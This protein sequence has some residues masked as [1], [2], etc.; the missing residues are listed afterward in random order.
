MAAPRG[1][2]RRNTAPVLPLLTIPRVLGLT[3]VFA[4]V[5]AG[6]LFRSTTIDYEEA[7]AAWEATLSSSADYRKGWLN[8]WL[9][10]RLADAHVIARFPS[11]RAA[12]EQPPTGDTLTPLPPTEE[13]HLRRALTAALDDHATDSIVAIDPQ[14]RIAFAQGQFTPPTTLLFA[15][16]ARPPPTCDVTV[17]GRLFL[18]FSAPVHDPDAAGNPLVGWV[19]LLADPAARLWPL[20]TRERVPT[21]T[22][23]TI[24]LRRDGDRIVYV[25]PLRFTES[26]EPLDL[27]ADMPNLAGRAATEGR[28][29]FAEWRDYRGERI[30]AATR[31]L[32]IPGWGLVR[33]VDA[34][35]AFAPYAKAVR[36]SVLLAAVGVLA[37]GAVM[38]SLS[39]RQKARTLDAALRQERQ[40]RAVEERYRQLINQANDIMLV[41]QPD[42]RIVEANRRAE[43]TYGYTRD[44]L[45]ELNARALRAPETQAPP[46]ED[47]LVRADSGGIVVEG[48]HRRR[49]GSTFPV[50]A[51]I[52]GVHLSGEHLYLTVIRDITER[53]RAE[54]ALRV[55][56]ARF[57][58]L[59]DHAAVAMGILD[60]D[61]RIVEANDALC[62]LAGLPRD[63]L[64]GTSH[65]AY[66]H[67][68]DLAVT[69]QMFGTV[70]G[71]TSDTYILEKRYVTAGAH[72][73]WARLSAA[74][75]RDG[76]GRPLYVTAIIDDITEQKLAAEAV[77][78]ANAELEERVAQR[79]A[80]L[81]DANAELSAF[82]YS[83][84][85]DLRAP[86]RHIEGFIRI[87]EEDYADRLP[88]EGRRY[89]ERVRAGS[90][91]LNQLIDALLRLVRVGRAELQPRSVN[92]TELAHATFEDL[93]QHRN[94]QAIDFVVGAL[95]RTCGDPVLLR[96]L[97][98]NLIGNAIKFTRAVPGARIE[99]GIESCN[100]DR[101]FYV[102][103]NGVGFDPAYAE[104]LFRVFQ[105]LHSAHDFEGTGIGLS[106]VKRIVERHGGKV[107]AESVPGQG[108]TFY[109]TLPEPETGP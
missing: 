42:G 79:T 46:P 102:R 40:L 30:L 82:N 98:D 49:D 13:Q 108:A 100:G 53:R 96:E 71:G 94:G 34:A 64:L 70:A 26:K 36:R 1:S 41:F 44:E 83:V 61:G 23:E 55:S 57:R 25:S 18:M 12:L 62:K 43:E 63:G 75:I 31:S 105:R 38:L 76:A 92:L 19:F 6:I 72:L 86:L 22:G 54:E 109:F 87:L 84:S 9:D 50:E 28:E 29:D 73:I 15:L 80:E 37:F 51:G 10:E 32:N 45:L 81:K 58:A 91:R 21:E 39:R 89:L 66:S 35:E 52:V 67:P 85:H 48:I 33:K 77:R 90:V 68:D 27:P 2:G 95:P 65:L 5:V 69:Q 20:L 97:F 106:I 59:F 60:L 16:A 88:P 104:R 107:W 47:L 74:L 101:V 56:E 3:A 17:D 93:C 8:A 11:V 24:L 78:Q 7:R 99:V 14:G 103:D 4:L